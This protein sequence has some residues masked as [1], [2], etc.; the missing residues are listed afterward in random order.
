LDWQKYLKTVKVGKQQVY[1]FN[2]LFFLGGIVFLLLVSVVTL[3]VNG[4]DKEQHFF[5]S[6]PSDA[7]SSCEN[8]LYHNLAYC[9]KTLD[10]EGVLCQ[11]PTIF[12]GGSLGVPPPFIVKHFLEV[13]LG[14]VLV[15]FLLNHY[16]LNK[17]FSFRKAFKEERA[18][19]KDDDGD[20]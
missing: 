19:Q 6:C 11:T 17:G 3:A 7:I 20:D 1:K 15:C 13:S 9:G 5:V 10:A 4:F 14:V 8:P 12:Q 2:S 16:F 18:E